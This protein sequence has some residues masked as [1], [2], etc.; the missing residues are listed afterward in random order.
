VR[1]GVKVLIFWF[2]YWLCQGRR[3]INGGGGEEPTFE[4]FVQMK[5][6]EC[7]RIVC[8]ERCITA[9][10]SGAYTRSSL[11]RLIKTAEPSILTWL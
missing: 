1:G 5:R 2:G 9:P 10:C 6:D 8:S 4:I 11:T 3:S 7:G